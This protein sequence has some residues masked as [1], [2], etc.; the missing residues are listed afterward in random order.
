L[1]HVLIA[2][3][4]AVVRRG[5]KQIV[6]EQ[7]DIKVLGEAQNAAEVRRYVSTRDWDV[8]VL[9][10]NMPDANGLEVLEEVKSL[11]PHLPI[12]ILSIH[13]ED[14]FG[15]RVLRAGAAGYLSKD[16]A[17][18]D[19]VN[20]IRKAHRGGKY[21][22]PFLAEKLAMALDKDADRPPH[23]A[24][25]DREFQVMCLIASGKT[26]SQ[27]GKQLCLSVKTVS[28]YRTRILEK[29]GLRTNADLT[30]YAIRNHLVE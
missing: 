20:A 21:V 23:D 12:L 5:I 14:Q 15:I 27:I 25:T 13:P 3:D 6:E 8:L 18:E 9:D 4:H 24:L 28:T 1:I 16:S 19:L 30:S 17:P 11:K 7:P 26:V 22:T 2:D 29:M 10:I